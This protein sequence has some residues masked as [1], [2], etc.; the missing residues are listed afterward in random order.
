MNVTHCVQNKTSHKSFY[1]SHQEESKYFGSILLLLKGLGHD[2]S[3][4]LFTQ[5]ILHEILLEFLQ[6]V[7]KNVQNILERIER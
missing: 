5:I 2:W 1:N 7:I 4:C 6:K 3:Q